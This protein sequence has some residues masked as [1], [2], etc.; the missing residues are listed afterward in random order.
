MTISPRYRAASCL[1]VLLAGFGFFRADC[2]AHAES[3]ERLPPWMEGPLAQGYEELAVETATAEEFVDTW[4][5]DYGDTEFGGWRITAEAIRLHRSAAEPQDILFVP[6]VALSDIV[7]LNVADLKFDFQNGPRIGLRHYLVGQCDIEMHYFGIDGWASW[8]VR[9]GNPLILFPPL[10]GPPPVGVTV[11]TRF[12]VD[13]GSDLYSTEASLRRRCTP[14]LDLLAGLRWVQLNEAFRVVGADFSPLPIPR[15]ATHVENSIYGFQIGAEAKI[16]G[17]GG[18]LGLDRLNHFPRRLGRPDLLLTGP[19][20]IDG[21]IKAG[22]FANHATQESSGQGGILGT[23]VTA[24]DTD[25]QPAFIGEL[26]VTGVCRL[27]DHFTL[28]AGYQAMW[29]EGVALAPEQIP[30]TDVAPF[31]AGTADLHA[32]GGLLFHG[33]HLGLEA[34]W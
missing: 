1:L 13:Y 22:V 24:S 26:G 7:A 10:S 4:P 18:F 5:G 11:S 33:C 15:Y 28:R 29:I 19:L 21:V 27:G 8:A 16:L 20:R 34:R 9:D 14:Y 25:D 23:V 2:L 32:T 30:F 17:G 12:A 31:G 6:A 3:A